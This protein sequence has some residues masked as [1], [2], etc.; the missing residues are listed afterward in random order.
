MQS[1]EI[2]RLQKTLD[3][4]RTQ[5]RSEMSS[6]REQADKNSIVNRQ[7]VESIVG[8]QVIETEQRVRQEFENEN[9]RLTNEV[10]ELNYQ[11]DTLSQMLGGA[12]DEAN[13]LRAEVREWDKRA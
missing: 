3:I 10:R 8:E 1:K 7:M 11:N 9:N 13:K 4:E 6:L 2:E 12:R 5:L